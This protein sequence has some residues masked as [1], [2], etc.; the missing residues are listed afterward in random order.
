MLGDRL[1]DQIDSLARGFNG[2][3]D[4]DAGSYCRLETC[5]DDTTLVADDGSL[6][7]LI[8]V[9]GMREICSA[10]DIRRIYERIQDAVGQRFDG[11]GHALQAVMTRDPENAHAQVHNVMA[12][13]RATAK[14]FGMNAAA[15]FDAWEDKLAEFCADESIIWVLWTRPHALNKAARKSESKRRG[16]AMSAAPAGREAQRMN[17]ALAALRDPHSSFVGTMLDALKEGGIVAA[18][19]EVHRALALL[20]HEIDPEFI[21]PD[22]QVYLPGDTVRLRAPLTPHDDASVVL[23]PRLSSQIFPREAHVK[24]GRRHIQIGNRIYAPLMITLPPK[25]GAA[26]QQLFGRLQTKPDLPWRVSL[27]VE[28]DGLGAMTWKSIIVALMKWGA[29]NKQLARSISDLK[30]RNV[31]GEETIARVRITLE[32]WIQVG[33]SKRLLNAR[34]NELVSSVQ[35][36]GASQ[37]QDLTGDPLVG[38]CANKPAYMLGSPAPAAAAPMSEVLPLLPLIRPASIWEQGSV[39]FRTPDGKLMPFQQGSSKQQAWIDIGI[40]PMG[41]GKSVLLNTLHWAF[42]T[43][44]GLRQLPM[45]SIIDIG[46][47]SSGLIKLLR[48][49]LPPNQRHF[50][51]YHRLRMEKRFAINPHDTVLGAR[52]PLPSEEAFQVNLLSLIATPENATAPPEGISDL[53]R[54]CVRQC[55]FKFDKTAPKRYIARAD[56]TVRECV[57][58]IGIEVDEQT[59]WWEIVD[60]LFDAGRIYEAT[61]AQRYAVPTVT[62]VAAMAKDQ[63]IKSKYGGSMGG[64]SR[65]DRC[66]YFF[67]RVRDAVSAWPILS[68]PTRFSIGDARIISLDLDEVA[69]KTQG[70][71]RQTAVVYMLARQV[72]GGRFF[73]MSADAELVPERYRAYH[74]NRIE[75]IRRDPKRLAFDEFHRVS[76][77][78]A[79]ADQIVSDLDTAVR[80]SRK[81]NLHIG[82]YSQR[83]HDIPDDILEM[84]TAVYILNGLSR[85]AAAQLGERQSLKSILVETIS[86]GLRQPG[87]HGADMVA[88]FDTEEKL[89]TQTLTNTLPPVLLWAFSTTTEDVAVRDKLASKIG[90]MEALE[91]IS[92][93][94]PGSVK[95]IVESKRSA[96]VE[97]TSSEDATDD[98]T[99]QLVDDLE[100]VYYKRKIA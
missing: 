51:Q 49:I 34:V 82:L 32:T 30:N 54:E 77:N 90:F 24:A 63:Q 58:E 80:E 68:E 27:F 43:A 87:K 55:Y 16:R 13:S 35:A 75:A 78:K 89:V 65:D 6:A 67:R 59:T 39:P 14:R 22:F 74:R 5:D 19:L 98:I 21:G 48:E 76:R 91:T 81:W 92:S 62:E 64:E 70:A 69:P 40:A 45:L 61:L 37:L 57:E 26:F 99:D 8:K 23:P 86:E 12:P 20:A 38:V 10:A 47:S 50:A 56:T 9:S 44:A 7:T 41:G 46:P 2:W 31:Q 93:V 83:M 18:P 85:Q 25:P 73:M 79:V 94:Y 96:M 11:A 17:A 84:S 29:A 42:C 33:E 52:Y 66:D 3:L 95:K 1:Y 36:W 71:A 53:A 100:Q 60:A 28:G 97:E 88:L 15:L 72:A 4:H